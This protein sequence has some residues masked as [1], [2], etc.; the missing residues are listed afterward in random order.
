MSVPLDP[1]QVAERLEALRQLY[2]PVSIEEARAW[3]ESERRPPARGTS[4]DPAFAETVQ[5]RLDELRALCELTQY[6]HAGAPTG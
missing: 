5:R 2:V 3:L 6:L 4:A 1:E